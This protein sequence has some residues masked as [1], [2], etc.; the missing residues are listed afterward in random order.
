MAKDSGQLS[1]LKAPD[2]GS[3]WTP[4]NPKKQPLKVV[5]VSGAYVFVLRDDGSKKR[6]RLE[7]LFAEYQPASAEPRE[8]G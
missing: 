8:G 7:R 4:R 2:M 6:I 1:S 5:L 3:R